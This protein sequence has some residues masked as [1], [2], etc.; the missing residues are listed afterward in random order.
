MAFLNNFNRLLGISAEFGCGADPQASTPTSQDL[1]PPANSAWFSICV[2]QT[3]FFGRGG[4]SDVD[5]GS[6][7]VGSTAVMPKVSARG[8][9]SASPVLRRRS[10]A[11]R[12]HHLA[13]L[14]YES[15]ALDKPL[16]HLRFGL[17]Q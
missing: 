11:L 9:P 5:C 14:K 13:E 2:K 12:I 1:K 7:G 16:D 15:G 6:S 4:R 17:D 3:A 10:G 8:P